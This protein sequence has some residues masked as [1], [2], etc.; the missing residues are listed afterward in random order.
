M[1]Q[2]MKKMRVFFEYFEDVRKINLTIRI[3]KRS[4]KS[5]QPPAKPEA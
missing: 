4:K 3:D 5:R 2:I 1:A